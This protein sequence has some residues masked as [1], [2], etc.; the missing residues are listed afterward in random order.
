LDQEL[1]PLSQLI[2][3]LLGKLSSKKP[4]AASFQ[5]GLGWIWQ[6]CS[7]SKWTSIGKV[8]FLTMSCFQHG[9]H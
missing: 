6:D 8:R 4:K 3:F 2:L 1:I 5:I 9:G 7:S